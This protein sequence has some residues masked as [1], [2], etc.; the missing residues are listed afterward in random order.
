MAIIFSNYNTK[1]AKLGIFVLKF[2]DFNFA[3]NFG[4]IDGVDFKY[5]NGFFE[6]QSK[7]I[8]RKYILS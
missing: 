1:L 7:N 2:K 5:D 4:I 6:F 8:Q 3:P